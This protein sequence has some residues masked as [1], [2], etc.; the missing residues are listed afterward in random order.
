MWSGHFPEGLPPYLPFVSTG[1]E[2]GLRKWDPRNEHDSHGRARIHALHPHR[3]ETQEREVC[4]PS[5][6]C[7]V[8][9]GLDRSDWALVI[10]VGCIKETLAVLTKL[11]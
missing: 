7:R 9:V 5:H 8:L 4:G 3:G 2:R 10:E 1:D 6:S 11:F